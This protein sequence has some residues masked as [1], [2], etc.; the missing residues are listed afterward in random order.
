MALVQDKQTKINVHLSNHWMRKINQYYSIF[1]LEAAKI[2]RGVT[3]GD[4][5]MLFTRRKRKQ[6]KTLASDRLSY[7]HRAL[8]AR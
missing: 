7:D 3:G 2:V 5:C 6:T 4:T 8:T 1:V